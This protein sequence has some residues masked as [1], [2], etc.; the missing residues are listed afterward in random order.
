MSMRQE[1]GWLT[2]QDADW[3]A[4]AA[5]AEERLASALPGEPDALAGFGRDR[6]H[7]LL[8]P[9]LNGLRVFQPQVEQLLAERE[10]LRA[11]LSELDQDFERRVRATEEGAL[12][13]AA[14]RDALDRLRRDPAEGAPVFWTDEGEAD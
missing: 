7:A 1:Q 5:P 13:G 10:R 6:Q 2:S 4:P 12:I 8:Q 14:V 9:G 11:E 3:R